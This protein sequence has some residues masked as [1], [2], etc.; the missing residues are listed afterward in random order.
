M[1]RRSRPPEAPRQD[2]PAAP[3]PPVPAEVST[4]LEA[5]RSFGSRDDEL[6]IQADGRFFVEQFTTSQIVTAEENVRF[7]KKVEQLVR[8]SREYKAFIGHLRNDLGMNRCSF[9][10]GIDMTMDDVTLEYHHCPLTLYQIVDVVMSHRLNSGQAVTSLT[11]ADEVLQAHMLGMVGV[12]PLARTVHKLVHAGTV[13]VH[14]SQIHGDWLAFLRAYPLG[15]SEELIAQ[16]LRF[17]ATTEDEV[18]EG[19]RKI[20]AS[21]ATPRLRA[22]VIV[23]SSEEINLLLM[24]PA[25]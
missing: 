11:V 7:I 23:P 24:A 1:A 5:I 17:V 25:S 4:G 10:S 18:V 20:D 15:I 13:S 12:L 3:P 16:L 9:L 19:A 6:Y 14:P 21:A 2:A 22:D 8:T